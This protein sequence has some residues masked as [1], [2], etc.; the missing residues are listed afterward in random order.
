MKVQVDSWKFK[1]VGI[2]LK[3]YPND[4]RLSCV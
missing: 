1:Q 3:N 4:I 2:D